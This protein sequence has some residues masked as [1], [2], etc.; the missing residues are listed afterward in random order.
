MKTEWEVN[1]I[2]SKDC[3]KQYMYSLCSSLPKC[4]LAQLDPS[5]NQTPT[6]DT[7]SALLFTDCEYGSMDR[8]THKYYIR[9]FMSST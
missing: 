8:L 3:L 2:L 6:A 4:L 7:L 1:L 5:G 9:I